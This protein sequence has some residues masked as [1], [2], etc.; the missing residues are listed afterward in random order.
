M[1]IAVLDDDVASRKH[2]HRL[3]TRVSDDNK[4]NGLEGY[5]IDLYG[6]FQS[7]SSKLAMYDAI[8]IDV[9][10]DVKKGHELAVHIHDVG[11]P[12]KIILMTSKIKY[13]DL[14]FPE[15]VESFDFI[16]KPIDTDVLNSIL[17]EC[18]Q[19]R[20][21]REPKIEIRTKDETLYVKYEEFIYAKALVAGKTT[22]VLSGP[23]DTIYYKD[24]A[25]VR[26]AVEQY[27]FMVPISADVIASLYHITKVNLMSVEMDEGSVFKIPL[28]T[29]GKLKKFIENYKM[30]NGIN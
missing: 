23:R 6:N 3:L 26:K 15:Y 27:P 16:D 14:L 12:G 11:I 18:E 29:S 20:E 13:Y 22:I 1:H 28:G 9:V 5:Y 19:L 8:F 4:K 24:I 2:M 10:D 17:D 30:K 7:L 21:Q 25:L